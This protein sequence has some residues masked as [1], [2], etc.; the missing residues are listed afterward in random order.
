MKIK[1]FAL[2]LSIAALCATAIEAAPSSSAQRFRDSTYRNP[3]GFGDSSDNESP[4]EVDRKGTGW[5]FHRRDPRPSDI[6]FKEAC[7]A[8]LA[9]DL[10]AACKKFDR[11]VRS[12]PF[13]AEA[14]RSQY[15]LGAILERRGKYAKAFEEYHY[16]LAI[17]PENDKTAAVL[18]HMF[19]IA[20]WQY[21][22]RK[23]DAAVKSFAAI[24]EIAPGWAKTPEA[25]FL[26]GK[27]R[28]EMH[29][30]YEAA[31]AFDVVSSDY[32]A[33]E[34]AVPAMER[35]AAALYALSLKY[36]EDEAVQNRAITVHTSAAAAL[37]AD[38]PARPE[39]VAH[40]DDLVARRDG[41]AIAIA[42]F[43]DSKR[44][45]K[46]SAVSAYEEFLRQHPRSPRA[47]EARARLEELQAPE[48]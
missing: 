22:R 14:A 19:A 48:M 21:G 4:N 28:L 5:I 11:L 30:W 6:Q 39:L 46:E 12:W 23:R 3:D 42:K 7:D 1:L 20:N 10:S 26:M 35:H 29:D 18:D 25:I 43:Y 16:L 31:E 15:N 34:F 44:F 37:P 33:S 9:G 8:Y 13:S 41:R 2:S 38:D 47:P 32:P 45:K 17:Y 36:K 27:A 24:A 40:L